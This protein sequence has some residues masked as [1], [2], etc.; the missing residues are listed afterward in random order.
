[1]SFNIGAL[2]NRLPFNRPLGAGGVVYP[3]TGS[4]AITQR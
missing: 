4:L 2:F 3:T 1:M